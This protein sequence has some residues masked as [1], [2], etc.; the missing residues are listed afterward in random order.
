[1][2]NADDTMILKIAVFSGQA[3]S[4][5]VSMLILLALIGLIAGGAAGLLGVGGG[6]IMVPAL[7]FFAEPLGLP[8]EHIM[9]VAAASSTAVVVPT[10]LRS[11]LQHQRRGAVDIDLVKRWAVPAALGGLAAGGLSRWIPTDMLALLFACV[12]VLVGGNLASGWQARH[13]PWRWP[14]RWRERF[15]ASA[16]GLIS[17]WMGIGGGTIGYPLLAAHGIKA[18]RAVGT[19]AALGLTISLPA[20]IGWIASG[21]GV[22]GVGHLQL[23]FVSLPISLCLLAPS[24]LAVPYGAALSHRLPAGILSRFFGLFLIVSA[25][26][27]ALKHV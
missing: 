12:A 21:W 11:A 5:T 14:G 7:R 8:P 16:M 15:Y 22:L 17:A 24:L 23:G 3:P 13:K 20:L 25:V 10:A 18:H 9:H 26:G 1:M 6:I 19:S 4:M 27:L 2:V